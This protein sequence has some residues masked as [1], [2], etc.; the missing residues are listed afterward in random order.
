MR[1]RA[2]VAAGAASWLAASGARAQADGG[3]PRKVGFLA[4]SRPSEGGLAGPDPFVDA[5]RQLGWSEG[6]NIVFEHRSSEGRNERL[7]ELAADLVRAQVDVIVVTSGATGAKAAREAS[8]RIPV[9]MAVVADPLKFGLVASFARPGGNVTGVALP[10]VDWGKWLELAKE[11]GRGSRPVAVIANSTNIVYADYVARNQEAAQRLGLQL[12]MVP[13]ASAE[14]LPDAFAAIRRVNAGA[15]IVG[16]D[17]LLFASMQRILEL[18]RASRVPVFA[19][20]RRYAEQGAV[21]S[22]GTDLNF[23]LRRAASYVDRILRGASPADLPVEQP[24][25]FELVVN[26]SAAR[27]FG[28]AV[29]QSLLLRADAVIQ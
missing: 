10:L 3:R 24:E 11:C 28:V 9:V 25:R 1:R 14:A 18:A 15:L 26:L 7:P 2:F 22:F 13:L 5:L 17:P 19:S 21:V 16:P 27:E 23:V 20:N 6:R 29:P 8:S 12:Q 4:F